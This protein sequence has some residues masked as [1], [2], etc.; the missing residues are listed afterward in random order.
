VSEVDR[1]LSKIVEVFKTLGFSEDRIND[2][3]NFVM[4]DT[5]CIPQYVNT[6]GFLVEYAD[7]RKEALNNMYDDSDAF[8][9]DIGETKILEGILSDILVNVPEV[10]KV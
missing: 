4:S 9:L 1:I 2:R 8:P 5:Y 3:V 6:I 10:N 7:S